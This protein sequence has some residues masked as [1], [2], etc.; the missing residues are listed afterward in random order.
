MPLKLVMVAGIDSGVQVAPPFVVAMM[1]GPARFESNSLTASQVEALLQE[2]DVR[3]PTFVGTDSNVQLD[4]PLVV[5]MTTGF[6]KLPNP[7]A[8]QVLGA[9]HETPLNPSIAP[10]MALGVQPNPPFCD[11]RT[12]SIPTA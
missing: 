2:T 11:I 4:P 8:M 9:A 7:T 6:P 10:G 5:R 3:F 1:L 12:V